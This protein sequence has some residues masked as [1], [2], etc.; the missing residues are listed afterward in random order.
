MY[1][2]ID[3]S[4]F[5]CIDQSLTF[6]ELLEHIKGSDPAAYEYVIGYAQKILNPTYVLS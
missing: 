4:I 6:A 1:Q 2:R 5:D 3:T